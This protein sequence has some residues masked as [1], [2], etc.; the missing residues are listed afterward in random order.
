[1]IDVYAF[2]IR[3]LRLED[4]KINSRHGN[5]PLVY[6]K[7]EHFVTAFFGVILS[8]L[9]LIYIDSSII[10]LSQPLPGAVNSIRCLGL[11]KEIYDGVK[12]YDEAGNIQGVSWVDLIFNELGMWG[13]VQ[14]IHIFYI[15]LGG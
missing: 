6:D 1:M 13:A 8:Y 14:A 15:T 2:Q 11:L 4:D 12:P 7:L 9:L 3:F 5:T 10:I